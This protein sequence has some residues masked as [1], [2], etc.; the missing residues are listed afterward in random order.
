MPRNTIKSKD[1]TAVYNELWDFQQEATERVFDYVEAYTNDVTDE[2]ALVA[3]PTGSG[4]TAI[5][6][7]LA[8]CTKIK[9]AILVVSP[10]VAVST[11]IRNQ[12]GDR[13][14]TSISANSKNFFQKIDVDISERKVCDYSKP[15]DHYLKENP[16]GTPFVLVCTIQKIQVASKHKEEYQKLLDNVSLVIFDEG[17]YEPATSW[18]HTI[19]AFN[20][21]RIIFTAT[22]FRN[23]LKSFDIDWDLSYIASYNKIVNK[24][25]IRHIE[26]FDL[27]KA[28]SAEAFVM[29]VIDHYKVK[30]GDE[31][32]N[33]NKIIINCDNR[34]SIMEMAKTLQALKVDFIAIHEAFDSGFVDA[35]KDESLKDRLVRKVPEDPQRPNAPVVWIHQYKLLE[36][37]DDPSFRVLAV[38][39]PLRNTRSLVQQIGRIIRNPERKEERAF[40]FNYTDENYLS[41]WKGFLYAEDEGYNQKSFVENAFE[42]INENMPD[43]MYLEGRFRSKLNMETFSLISPLEINNVVQLPLKVNFFERL[44]NFNLDRYCINGIEKQLREDD[45]IY[46]SYHI[47]SNTR[48]YLYISISNS[49]FLKERYFPV[50]S[51]DVI[52]I[53]AFPEYIAYYTSSGKVPLGKSLLGIGMGVNPKRLKRIFSEDD[54]T[55]LI[56]VS[57]NNSAMGSR[58]LRSHSFQAPSIEKSTPFLNDFTHYITSA[59]GS[60]IGKKTYKNYK[61]EPEGDG[62]V[63]LRTYV[64]FKN[65]RIT[66]SESKYVSL[67]EY[68]AWLDYLIDRISDVNN[69]PV[70]TFDRYANEKL[71]VIDEVPRNILL[72]LFDIEEQK[73]GVSIYDIEDKCLPIKK[74][75]GIYFF[76]LRLNE[77]EYR[78]EIAFDKEVKKFMLKAPQLELNAIIHDRANSQTSSII[79]QL[80]EHQAFRILTE[81]HYLYA[82][83]FF[84]KTS[85]RYGRQLNE[86]NFT[87]KKIIH[88]IDALSWCTS[89][90]GI[91]N[92]KDD[93]SWQE[94]SIFNLIDTF[95]EKTELAKHFGTKIDLLVCDDMGTECADF[96]AITDDNRLIFI[97]AKGKGNKPTQATQG[98]G[99]TQVSEVCNQAIKNIQYISMFDTKKPKHLDRWAKEYSWQY[100]NEKQGIDFKIRN[101]IR[102]NTTGYTDDKAWDAIEALKLNPNAQKEV[103]AVIGGSFSKDRF[104]KELTKDNPNAEVIQAALILKNTLAAIGSLGASFKVFCH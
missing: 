83:G 70:T 34:Y 86:R 8:R 29:D 20:V 82:N 11:Q 95:G 25:Y 39:E 24:G 26:I 33:K 57:L 81:K 54:K 17:H 12:I 35:L 21:P 104:I 44:N 3:M 92:G 13:S 49:G 7:A 36:G 100:K 103:W 73:E 56:R 6:A 18:S 48:I 14:D 90:K 59:F 38:Y 97:H 85:L 66:Q 84:Y 77:T 30:I 53:K 42:L 62:T 69:V 76:K 99:A 28:D 72:D 16:K 51:N 91:K 88:G 89:E 27:G 55:N 22:P 31:L 60:Y 45:R 64:G 41:E 23:D 4:K 74:Y 94:K 46:S 65:G 1:Y 47:D 52:L 80:N 93:N 79:R 43:Q 75:K 50:I 19:R 9:G 37:I 71:N 63:Q 15:L 10:R 87:L 5:I 32:S 68:L 61:R 40:V 2:S 78:I 58:E 96:I 102:R 98:Y 67:N 101:R